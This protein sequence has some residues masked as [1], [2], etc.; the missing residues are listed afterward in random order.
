[1][2]FF[3]SFV[4]W[5]C[6]AFE[7]TV[8]EMVMKTMAEIDVEIMALEHALVN[9]RVTHSAFGDDHREAIRAQIDVLEGRMDH[10]EVQAA[11]GED[12]QG[13]EFSEPVFDDALAACDWMQGYL[14]EDAQAPSG[15]DGW[16]SLLR[17]DAQAQSEDAAA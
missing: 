16:G 11:Y 5:V 6:R 7:Q 14:G 1:V 13:E 15:P 8:K 2:G 12:A 4:M 3:K 9:L 17:S 10:D